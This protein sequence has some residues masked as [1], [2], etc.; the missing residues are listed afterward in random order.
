M[1]L[2]RRLPRI[3]INPNLLQK[4]LYLRT[5][6]TQDK[7]DAQKNITK[8]AST[9]GHFRRQVSSFRDIIEKDGKFQ[10]EKGEFQR[11]GLIDNLRF[12]TFWDRSV[13]Y[14]CLVCV[15]LGP[16]CVDHPKVAE[17]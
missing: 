11:V 16:P 5:M 15:S 4:S 6:S 14:I 9:D 1:L 8:W 13:P 7:S 2:V 3:I 10:P 17:A 12:L